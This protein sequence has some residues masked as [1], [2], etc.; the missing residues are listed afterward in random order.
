MTQPR[1]RRLRLRT[2]VT[3]AFAFGALALSVVL[4]G[5]S[6]LLVRE[7]LID[8]RQR[9]AVTEAFANAGLARDGLR[10]AQPDLPRVLGSLQT[11][12]ESPSVLR[13]DQSW[14]STQI[15]I[16]EEVLPVSLRDA[17]GQGRQVRQAYD[18]DA[19]TFLAVGIP[20]PGV[21]AQ[22]FEIFSFGELERT[23]D[24]LGFA[25]LGAG[26]ATT[27]AG[28]AVG[29]WASSRLLRPVADVSQAA[30]AIAAG[31]L[32][33]RLDGIDDPDL[34]T[35]TSS[36]NAMVDALRARIERD[37]RFASDVS[38]ELRS[39]LTTLATTVDVLMS[40]RAEL[41]KKAQ[42]ALDLLEADVARFQRLV[43][44]LLEISRFDAG[45][46][47]L[48]TEEVR[49]G[50]LVRRVVAF[51]AGPDLPVEIGPGVEE[52]LVRV[53]KRRIGQVTFNL[54]E[55]A[56]RYGG[57]AQRV[58]VTTEGSTARIGVEDA[59]PGIPADERTAVFERFFRG[60]ASGRRRGGGQGSGLGLSLVAEHVRLHGGAVWVEDAPA[61]G[62]R[63]VVELPVVGV[64]VPD[65]VDVEVA[66]P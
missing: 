47:E 59:G 19:G 41:P 63:F 36:F 44:D 7:D 2:R 17:V 6:Y 28:A 43:E 42:A 11:P 8:Q 23:L 5:L 51:S 10:S 52:A 15:D 32:D 24:F 53:D 64:A 27:I 22:Y 54:V 34:S 29:R 1:R 35:L 18:T 3:L 14:L 56:G 20:L 13:F 4:G 38:H 16:T 61:G 40:R 25:L 37:A 60:S 57:G 45:V 49:L 62:A 66:G 65:D 58:T 48:H 26:V 50:E 39:P 30:A 55:N 12:R 33:T 9:S 46:T 31:A 21:G